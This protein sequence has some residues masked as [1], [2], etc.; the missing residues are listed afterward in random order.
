MGAR[1]AHLARDGGRQVGEQ[2]ARR[3][4]VAGD[5]RLA[6]PQPRLNRR[7]AARPRGGV[8]RR[9]RVQLPRRLARQPLAHG[10][11]RRARPPRMP[12]RRRVVPR[13]RRALTQPRL[14]LG[15]E[16]ER[17]ALAVVIE[18][19]LLDE[20]AARLVVAT[21]AE[22]R[23]GGLHEERGVQTRPTRGGGEQGFRC[24]P[25]AAGEQQRLGALRRAVRRR[26]GHGRPGSGGRGSEE[27]EEHRARSTP[28]WRRRTRAAARWNSARDNGVNR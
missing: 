9:R 18:P 28:H 12:P 10:E 7:Q 20:Q 15:D 24:V 11:Q 19:R 25:G 8:R 4:G 23:A 1:I 17:L 16:R 5:A 2:P 13:R 3:R 14:R 22:F 26:L 27:H 21:R 6:Q